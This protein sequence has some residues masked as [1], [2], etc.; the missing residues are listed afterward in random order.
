MIKFLRKLW[1]FV[2]PY[3]ARFFLGLACGIIYAITSG[4]IV[5]VIKPVI[6][7]VFSGSTNFHD[8]LIKAPAIIR[9]FA[10]W[11]MSMVPDVSAPSTI[12]G[13]VAVISII[14]AVML[15]R[16]VTAYISIY[17]V[18]WSAAHAV[19]DIRTTLFEHLQNLSLGFFSRA[20]TGDLISRISNDTQILYGI[21]G[22]SFATMVKDPVTII[23]ILGYQLVVQPRLTLVSFVVLPLCLVPIIVYGRKVRKSAREMQG[24]ISNLTGLMHESFTGNRIIKAYN[25][26]QTVVGQ[27]RATTRLYIGQAMRIIRSN[28]IPSQSMEFLA[29]LGVGLVFLYVIHLPK[30]SRPTQG[31]LFAFIAAIFMIYGPIKNLTR[32]HNQLHQAAS[33]SQRIFELLQT[34]S[35]ILDP[36]RPVPLKA[37]NADISF[38]EID[39]DYGEKPVLRGINIHVKAGQ[40]LALVGSSGSGKTTITNLLL[41]FYD[42]QKGSVRI[43]DLDVR[44]VALKDLRS[45]IALVAQETIL[46][47]DTIR[48][49]IA[50]GR[51]GATDGEIEAAATY[52]NAHDF[53]MQKPQGYDTIV[54]EKGIALSGGQRQRLAIARAVLKNAPILVLDEATNALDAESERAV[55]A[56][57]EKLMQGRTTICIAHRL[58]TIQRADI[59]AV[60]HEGRVVEM[61]THQELNGRGG[62]YRRLYELQFQS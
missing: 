11:I 56:G 8:R 23:V 33:A 40:I 15:V 37:D 18:N 14:P 44:Q 10:Q 42:P 50:V 6:D 3:R 62:T 51:P 49:N 19:A 39:F 28:E 7:L 54:G 47:H 5:A 2:H 25:L 20:K 12:G 58:S 36:A 53:I 26:E 29:A 13:W 38:E 60:L 41:R 27:F 4:A 55:Q 21:I 32:L 24:H 30:D 35:T 31:D 45:Q 61:G 16:V 1:P 22:S 52:A 48:R 57:L 59:I 34:Q 46:F 43:G 17:L 9:P